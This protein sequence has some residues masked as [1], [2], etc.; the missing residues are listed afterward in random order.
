MALC[1]RP[2]GKLGRLG[3][4]KMRVVVIRVAAAGDVC[5]VDDNVK[6]SWVECLASRYRR[7][8]WGVPLS[9]STTGFGVT[10][11]VLSFLILRWKQ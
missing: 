8:D 1:G 7:Q 2:V 9:D 11:S 10:L 5:R 3:R 4:V 6:T